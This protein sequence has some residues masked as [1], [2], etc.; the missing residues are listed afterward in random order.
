MARRRVLKPQ[1]EE[2]AQL[3]ELAPL[4]EALAQRQA[5]AVEE[6]GSVPLAEPAR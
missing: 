5:A 3:P 2:P 4:L 1:L 6:A